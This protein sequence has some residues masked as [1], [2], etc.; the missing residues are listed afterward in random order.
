MK[1]LTITFAFLFLFLFSNYSVAQFDLEK[2]I[3]KKIEKKIEKEVDKTID[4]GLDEAV[5][6]GDKKDEETNDQNV[7]NQKETVELANNNTENELKLWSKYDF[8]PGDK[9]IFEDNLL[10]EESGEF[11]SRWD[12]ISGS[13]EIAALGN[14]DVIHLIHNNTII[15]PLMDNKNFLSDVFTIEF[16]IYFEKDAVNRTD[17]YKVRFFEGSGSSAPLEGKKKKLPIEISWDGV[18]M[19]QFGG[20]TASFIEEK[21]NWQGKWRHIAISF[22]KKSLKLYMDEE[23]MLNIP[24]LGYKP[25]MFSI[26]VTFDNRFIKMCSI[27][28]TRVNEGGKKLYDRII[29]DGKFITYGIFFDV[30]KAVIKGESMGT[31]NDILK[32]MNEHPDLKFRIEGHTDNDGDE[33]FNQE[34]SE[35][36]ALSVKEALVG[37]GIDSSRLETQGFGESKPLNGNSTS[38]EKANNRRVEFM[39]I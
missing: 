20:K 14:D 12:L 23:R 36:R 29:S 38:E 25:E 16:D 6:E 7:K 33:N 4:K 32:L 15:L 8:V 17:I 24:N 13:A 2:K 39:K 31:I 34:L 18:K 3:K 1:T 37:L 26:G 35:N 9:I 22:N 30:N 21:K 27:K 11:P 10:L 19:G 28:G 5:G